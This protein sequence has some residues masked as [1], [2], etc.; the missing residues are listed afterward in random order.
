MNF[1]RYIILAFALMVSLG[2]SMV[3]LLDTALSNRTF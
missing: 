2:I 3:E 1:P